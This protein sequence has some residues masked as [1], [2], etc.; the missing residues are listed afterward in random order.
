MM[1]PSP[2]V[3]EDERT[4]PAKVPRDGFDPPESAG[5]DMNRY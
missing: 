2:T 5:P 1:W 4:K 3:A